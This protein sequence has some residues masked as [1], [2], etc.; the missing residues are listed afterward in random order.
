M[1]QRKSFVRCLVHTHF[2]THTEACIPLAVRDLLL[3]PS[4]APVC[5]SFPLPTT[6]HTSIHLTS[7][8][9]CLSVPVWAFFFVSL[10]Y[11][12]QT[13]K[14]LICLIVWQRVPI[15]HRCVHTGFALNGGLEQCQ[16][17][18][19]PWCFVAIVRPELVSIRYCSVK[20]PNR[21][22]SEN[23]IRPVEVGCV[24]VLKCKYDCLNEPDASAHRK[25]KDLEAG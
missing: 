5:S 18:Q 9:L 14:E 12:T 11:H 6:F 24:M 3:S 7:S 4:G 25:K 1:Q 13:F 22:C 10:P 15:M 23:V 20:V 16:Q 8:S 17:K 19:E 2:C 21:N